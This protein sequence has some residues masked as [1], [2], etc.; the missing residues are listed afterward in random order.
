MWIGG[1]LSLLCDRQIQDAFRAANYSPE[2]VQ[3]LAHAVRKKNQAKENSTRP[4][5]ENAQHRDTQA[6]DNGT[7]SVR[8]IREPHQP[9]LL[10]P[11]RG[12]RQS[13]ILL[14]TFIEIV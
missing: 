4:A 11:P 10:E 14:P 13:D 6:T 8:T 1:W 9:P 3:T 5:S 12:I 2:E 7:I